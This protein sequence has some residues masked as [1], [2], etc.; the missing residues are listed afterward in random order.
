MNPALWHLTRSCPVAL[1]QV[2]AFRI[3]P[4]L[5][6]I[7]FQCPEGSS[8]TPCASGCPETCESFREGPQDNSSD[9]DICRRRCV[10]G[11]DCAD[12]LVLGGGRCVTPEDC[13]CRLGGRYIEVSYIYVLRFI[14]FIHLFG[15]IYFNAVIQYNNAHL[16]H[17][18]KS[19][20]VYKV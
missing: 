20:I 18:Y 13:G 15:N 9:P 1:G 5:A 8:Y 11:C 14:Y 7:A 19:N 17:N 2:L 3:W 4:D 10:E 12:G 6:S 16:C